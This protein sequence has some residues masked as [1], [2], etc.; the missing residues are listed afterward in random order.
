MLMEL[1][2]YKRF[3]PP[4]VSEVAPLGAALYGGATHEDL[5]LLPLLPLPCVFFGQF[6]MKCLV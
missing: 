3:S 4:L 6:L 2:E 1:S 5:S